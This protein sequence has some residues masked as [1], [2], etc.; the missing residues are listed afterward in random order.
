V[1]IAHL[2]KKVEKLRGEVAALEASV[3]DAQGQ[4][5][6][7]TQKLALSEGRNADLNKCYEVRRGGRGW[8][9]WCDLVVAVWMETSAGQVL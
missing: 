2:Q 3:R 5:V 8:R 1:Q 7:L 6:A 4:A 9:G